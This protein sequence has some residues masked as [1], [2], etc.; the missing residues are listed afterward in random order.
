MTEA[1]RTLEISLPPDSLA[2]FFPLFQDG[3]ELEV[4][5]GVTIKQLLVD[6]FGIDLDYLA[7]RITTIFLN[8]KTVDDTATAVLHDGS[9]LALS[10]AM[11]GLVGATLRTGS[12]Y[13]AMRG[14]QTYVAEGEGSGL[15]PGCI[16]IKL[17][18]LLL[19]ELGPHLLQ[20][21]ILLS[22]PQLQSLFSAKNASL[23]LKDCR[24]EGEKI[25]AYHLQKMGLFEDDK[26]WVK[27]KINGGD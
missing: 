15:M 10:G 24:I 11:P 19:Q 6:Q 14:S 1:V 13:A 8:G 5:V 27:L 21:G 22:G 17:F 25:M 12:F 23:L 3:V 16:K 26:R 4:R 9:V 20:H 7:G 18:N 2:I